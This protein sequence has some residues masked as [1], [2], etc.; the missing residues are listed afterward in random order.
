MGKPKWLYVY[1]LDG[2]PVR[3]DRQRGFLKGEIE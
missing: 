2:A 3:P 1:G